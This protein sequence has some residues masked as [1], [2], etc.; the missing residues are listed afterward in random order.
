MNQVSN[1]ELSF[2]KANWDNFLYAVSVVD[3]EEQEYKLILQNYQEPQ[4]GYH[5]LKHI[6]ETLSDFEDVKEMLQNPLEVQMAI[7]Y[8]DIIYDST[9][10]DNEEVSARIALNA[11]QKFGLGDSFGKRVHDLIIVTKGHLPS[12]NPD[13]R[14]LIDIDFGILGKDESRFDEYE[15]GIRKEYSQYPDKMYNYGRAE[16][17]KGFLERDFLYQTDYF[18]EKYEANARKNLQKVIEILQK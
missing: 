2:L 18:R 9:K 7:W 4:R 16:I 11:A 15:Q 17:L 13:S 6:Q 3:P 5:N 12:D 1:R 10:Q 14:Y 8:H